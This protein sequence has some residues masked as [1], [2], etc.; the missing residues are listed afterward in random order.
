MTPGKIIKSPIRS[1]RSRYDEAWREAECVA[2]V[3]GTLFPAVFELRIDDSFNEEVFDSMYVK[4]IRDVLLSSMFGGQ[5]GAKSVLQG[6][7]RPSFSP[8]GT[9]KATTGNKSRLEAA[10]GNL[11]T[12]NPLLPHLAA[13]TAK[14]QGRQRSRE[15]IR[16]VADRGSAVRPPVFGFKLVGPNRD[17]S[18]WMLPGT[19][20]PEDDDFH[21][22]QFRDDP[23]RTAFHRTILSELATVSRAARNP[24]AFM[25]SSRE[26]VLLRFYEIPCERGRLEHGF[27]LNLGALCY[28]IPALP[29]A[30]AGASSAQWQHRELLALPWC[31][32]APMRHRRALSYHLG[33][34]VGLM[35]RLCAPEETLAIG[36]PCEL[37]SW[38]RKFDLQAEEG[39]VE[40]RY[41]TAVRGAID[42]LSRDS[43]PYSVV[44]GRG[45]AVGCGRGE[46]KGGLEGD[47]GTA[48]QEEDLCDGLL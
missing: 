19:L 46:L 13:I 12:F 7:A 42:I 5:T 1:P 16:P 17:D 27:N 14:K 26:L 24:W 32:D 9:R 15:H 41:S 36:V 43:R 38:Y 22:S 4:E 33:L 40:A 3:S 25:Y 39:V 34:W 48:L 35:A 30:T 8:A 28:P 31:R 11:S 20:V 44:R 23:S 10:M 29:D 47:D 18:E 6:R 21:S 45:E 2:R 37:N